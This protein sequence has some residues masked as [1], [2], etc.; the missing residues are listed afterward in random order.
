MIQHTNSKRED[1]GYFSILMQRMEEI[2]YM[3]LQMHEDISIEIK[4]AKNT[5][6]IYH[7]YD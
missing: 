2:F 7:D 1:E 4:F 3:D 6:K 5:Y